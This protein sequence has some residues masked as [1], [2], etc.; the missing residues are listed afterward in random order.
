VKEKRFLN[1]FRG[2][3]LRSSIR[4]DEDIINYTGATLSSKAVA[5]GSSELFFCSTLFIPVKLLQ[6]WR[7]QVS[8]RCH[9]RCPQS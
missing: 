6:N 3:T 8:S 1:Q 4:V 7:P 9:F 5:R 2:K